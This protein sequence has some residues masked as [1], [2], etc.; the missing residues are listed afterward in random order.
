MTAVSLGLVLGALVCFGAFVLYGSWLDRKD[1][2]VRK[3]GD[4]G[5][6][7]GHG[8]VRDSDDDE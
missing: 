3:K 7:G 1:E 4:R 5:T 8:D 6:T 2:G